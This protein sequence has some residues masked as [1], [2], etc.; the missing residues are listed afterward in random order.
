[1]SFSVNAIENGTEITIKSC[2]LPF[3]TII[4]GSIGY[5]AIELEAREIKIS[6]NK[7]IIITDEKD[8]E[9]ISVVLKRFGKIVSR[10]YKDMEEWLHD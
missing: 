8:K 5:F 4:K 6:E 1:M 7:V 3:S 2:L 10:K 9:K